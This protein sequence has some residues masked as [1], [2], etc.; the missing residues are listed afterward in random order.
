MIDPDVNHADIYKTGNEASTRTESESGHKKSTMSKSMHDGI[1]VWC[2]CCSCEAEPYWVEAMEDFDGQL[3]PPLA[4]SRFR[5]EKRAT[6]RNK[7]KC[8]LLRGSIHSL[9]GKTLLT[10]RSLSQQW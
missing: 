2:D 5:R 10:S 9:L 7:K 8:C 3:K 4:K 6:A 1:E